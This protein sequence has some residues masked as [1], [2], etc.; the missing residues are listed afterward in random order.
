MTTSNQQRQQQIAIGT[1]P[2]R[3]NP[4]N[5]TCGAL[6]FSVDGQSHRDFFDVPGPPPIN[7]SKRYLHNIYIYTYIHMDIQI[8]LVLAWRAPSTV[9]QVIPVSWISML[10]VLD[11]R[12]LH[13]MSWTQLSHMPRLGDV[14]FYSWPQFCSD[15]VLTT[16]AFSRHASRPCWLVWNL[17]LGCVSVRT[18]DLVVCLW[19]LENP[20]KL[21]WPKAT[22]KPTTRG[23]KKAHFS[24][25]I[26]WNISYWIGI[27][28]EHT[29]DL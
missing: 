6:Y 2:S 20:T 28:W 12:V 9:E 13:I 23:L 18:S 27:P 1:R 7:E 19:M 17:Q 22:K 10:P 16:T 4:T 25:L 8:Y 11:K 21:C 29:W 3:F 26:H 15:F 14:L 5:W 24:R